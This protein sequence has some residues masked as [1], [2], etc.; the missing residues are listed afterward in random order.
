M[1]EP[2]KIFPLKN[3][4]S[5]KPRFLNMV[6]VCFCLIHSYNRNFF[7]TMPRRESVGAI[8]QTFNYDSWA[9][10]RLEFIHC[11]CRRQPQIHGGTYAKLVYNW[12]QNIFHVF[13]VLIVFHAENKKNWNKTRLKQRMQNKE[14]KIKTFLSSPIHLAQHRSDVAP[15]LLRCHTDIVTLTL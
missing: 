9:D 12:Y 4:G 2:Q 6:A 11:V 1:V 14:R 8:Y 3:I 13:A 7:N 5:F 10:D 15:L